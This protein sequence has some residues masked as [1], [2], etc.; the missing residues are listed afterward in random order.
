MLYEDD[1]LVVIDKPAGLVVHAGVATDVTLTDW[2]VD[3]YP[4]MRGVGESFVDQRGVEI[5]RHGIVHR[6]DK[7]T[8]GVIV[9][10]KN[11]GVF[12]TLKKH[13]QKRKVEKEYHAFVYGKPKHDRGTVSLPIGK[14][15]SNFRAFATH[16][17]RGVLRAARTEYVVVGSCDEGV[18]FVRLY[19]RTGRTHQIRVHV[20]S[21]YTPVV[22]DSLYAPSRE[23]I[24]G[25]SRLA[26]HARRVSLRL[27]YYAHPLHLV[28]PYPDD[29]VHAFSFCDASVKRSVEDAV[30]FS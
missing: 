30:T 11:Q 22:C 8:S 9:L 14:S 17:T 26:L 3:R 19:P 1:H 5:F 10:A 20:Q 2:V 15:R 27:H 28:A 16:H 23:P 29:F 25:F 13:F 7:E 12:D 21:L 18:S 4:E 24:L 6:L